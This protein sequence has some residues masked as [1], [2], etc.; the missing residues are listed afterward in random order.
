MNSNA[1]SRTPRP[2]GLANI[3]L[4]M[5][6]LEAPLPRSTRAG[7]PAAEGFGLSRPSQLPRV[8]VDP[9]QPLADA[10]AQVRAHRPRL[11]DVHADEMDAILRAVIARLNLTVDER[12]LPT[13]DARSREHSNRIRTSVLECVAALEH[14]DTAVVHE[15]GRRR[16]PIDEALEP[17]SG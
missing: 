2:K 10:A 14:L 6:N 11:H 9:L 16:L 17:P 5:L 15:F 8:T 13:H 4:R 3:A 7:L 1:S 12:Y